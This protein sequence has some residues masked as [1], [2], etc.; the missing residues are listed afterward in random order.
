MVSS[1][2]ECGHAGIRSANSREYA[3]MTSL[4]GSLGAKC[5]TSHYCAENLGQ[6]SRFKKQRK[7]PKKAT[8]EN[9]ENGFSHIEYTSE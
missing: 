7:Q 2:I 9:K 8:K 1:V 3:T 5:I 6:Q 4:G